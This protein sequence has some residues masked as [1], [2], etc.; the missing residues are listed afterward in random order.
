MRAGLHRSGARPTRAHTF[1]LFVG[2]RLWPGAEAYFGPELIALRPLSNLHG[3]G[4][5]IQNFERQR[6]GTETPQL[7]RARTFVRQTIQLGGGAV[8]KASD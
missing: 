7:Y 1:S 2:A 5:A 6:G 8:E 4:G 3:L